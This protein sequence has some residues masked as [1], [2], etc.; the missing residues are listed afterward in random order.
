VHTVVRDP[1]AKHA[2]NLRQAG[3]KGGCQAVQRYSQ[4]VGQ[5]KGSRL[6]S[7]RRIHA[8]SGDVSEAQ[9][10]IE[11]RGAVCSLYEA[12]QWAGSVVEKRLAALSVETLNFLF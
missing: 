11:A 7:L 1:H 8:C 9:R 3:A 12:T 4:D 6:W 5:G 2:T 10:S